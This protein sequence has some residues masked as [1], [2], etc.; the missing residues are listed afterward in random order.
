MSAGKI[1]A[2]EN[3]D[4]AIVGGGPSGLVTSL[5]LGQLGLRTAL[6]APPPDS[7]RKEDRRTAALL[8]GS[9]EFLRNLD[10]W[11]ITSAASAP[12]AAIRIIDSQNSLLRSPEVLFSAN[13]AGQE[14]FGWNVPN[15]PLVEALRHVAKQSE[16]HV[17][18]VE[19]QAVTA[20]GFGTDS[21]SLK[22]AERDTITATLAV[23]AE[24]RKSICRE[25][26]EIPVE[27]WSYPQSALTCTFS[28]TRPHHSISTEFHLQGGPI[29][30]VPLQGLA[31]S[32]VWVTG[33]ESANR[34]AQLP[35]EAFVS[36]LEGHLQ[37]LLGE[38]SGIGPRTL[39][40]LSGMTASPFARNR[41]ALVGEAAHLIPPIGAQGLNLS[42]R[43]AATLADIVAEALGAGRD[44]GE[45]ETLAKY[46]SARK[47]DTSSR[48]ALVDLLNRSL[49][50]DILPVH[51]ARGLGLHLLKAI[52]P[53]RRMIVREGLVPSL[54]QPTLMKSGGKARLAGKC[55]KSE[56][57]NPA[58]HVGKA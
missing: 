58:V 51:L 28:H 26:A 32:L 35:E 10:A 41:I 57:Q 14:S 30:T 22:L 11:D 40:P 44:I 20:V 29:T 49:L 52:G 33:P 55:R 38:L 15:G 45:P 36:E 48:V 19:T 25:A 54:A 13:D 2:V 37:G 43:D 34:L 23:G 18:F 39:F 27:T 6:V 31:S 4:V 17:T 9:I 47:L 7:N 24:G 56:A 1:P 46:S 5:A 8:P 50:T 53:L 21:V 16:S 3:Y 42:F 12:I